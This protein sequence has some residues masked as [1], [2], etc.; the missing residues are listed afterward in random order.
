MA[1]ARE[2]VLT[3]LFIRSKTVHMLWRSIFGWLLYQPWPYPL[4]GNTVR[5]TQDGTFASL[6]TSS[7]PP[8]VPPVPAF[9]LS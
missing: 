8:Q 4:A 5:T 3:N 9:A 1:S 7:L 2:L 6:R